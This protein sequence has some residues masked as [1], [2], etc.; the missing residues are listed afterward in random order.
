MF[1]GYIDDSGDEATELRTLSCF[2]GHWSVLF[3][4]EVAWNRVIDK[5]NRRLASAGRRTI[6]RFH[7]TDWSTKRKEF[8]GWSDDEKFELFDNLL[9]LFERYNVVGCG[10]SVFLKDVASVFPEAA[11]Q[12]KVDNLAHTLLFSL[13]VLFIDQNLLSR[14]PSYGADR[15]AF[16][17]DSEQFNGVLIDTLKEL[18]TDPGIT[19]RNRLVN[20]ELKTWQEETL[21]QPADLIAYENFKV[22]ERKLAGADMRITMKKIL[23]TEFRG[24]NARL[25][26]DLLQEW[27]D[28][29]N[30]ETLNRLFV[31]ARM[32]PLNLG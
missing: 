27:R 17:H 22:A 2:I 8:S 10:E 18:K 13:I 29:A 15:I 14:F 7:A 19:C 5:V 1:W 30:K 4:F 23:E 16:V 26:K 31:P 32:K 20:I 28:K 3:D 9:A 6:S 11:T 21:L 24:R 12:D 25:E